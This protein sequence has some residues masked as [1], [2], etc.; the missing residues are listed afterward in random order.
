MLN[1]QRSLITKPY[2]NKSQCA[3]KLLTGLNKFRR[4]YVDRNYK[5]SPRRER[6][7]YS[8]KKLHTITFSAKPSRIGIRVLQA[9]ST[10]LCMVQQS[11][12]ISA[13]LRNGTR[14]HDRFDSSIQATSQVFKRSK[15]YTL[16]SLWKVRNIS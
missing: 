4:R 14:G 3:G 10:E 2:I 7:D 12:Q 13:T 15:R 16:A 5:T 11:T 6:E 1:R 9:E 8:T